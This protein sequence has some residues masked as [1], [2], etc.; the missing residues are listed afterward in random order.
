MRAGGEEYESEGFFTDI[1]VALQ[2]GDM[3]P[4]EAAELVGQC[5]SQDWK[6]ITGG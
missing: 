1:M 5:D 3:T 2:Q 6:V 4:M